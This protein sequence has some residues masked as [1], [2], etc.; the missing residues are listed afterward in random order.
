MSVAAGPN[1]GFAAHLPRSC[2]CFSFPLPS[3]THPTSHLLQVSP[4]RVLTISGER[5]SERRSG[6]EEEGTLRV[7][8]S[9]GTFTRRLRLPEGVDVDGGAWSGLGLVVLW[10]QPRLCMYR[11]PVAAG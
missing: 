7:E 3:P 2:A 10:W 9:I 5:R 8:R 11:L 4:D 1:A 6:S